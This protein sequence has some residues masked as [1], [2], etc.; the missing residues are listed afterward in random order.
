MKQHLLLALALAFT[1]TACTSS[2]NAGLGGF[3][4][5]SASSGSLTAAAMRSFHATPA[6]AAEPR[7]CDAD[8]YVATSDAT[9][10]VFGQTTHD[11]A[12]KCKSQCIT[13]AGQCRTSC[14]S[15][16]CA[17]DCNKA[18]RACKAGC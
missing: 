10:D 13:E 6:P 14:S 16:K 5:S 18:E 7:A 17:N 1:A 2:L 12:S 4:A 11:G 8:A 15:A 9:R 3:G